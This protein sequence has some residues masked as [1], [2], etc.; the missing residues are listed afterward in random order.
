MPMEV[1]V[2]NPNAIALLQD[3]LQ[4][5]AR[6]IAGKHK[7]RQAWERVRDEVMIPSIDQNFE[8]EGRPRKWED[9]SIHTLNR[10]PDRSGILDVSGQMRRSATAKARFHIRDNEMTYGNWPQRRWFGPIHD[11]GTADIPKRQ[12][13]MIQQPEDAEHIGEII[14]E[15]LEDRVDDNI[16]LRYF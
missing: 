16:K 10:Q 3:D 9:V 1:T 12:F 6:D 4:S 13:V 8:M 14:M 7:L 2:L 11:F 15:W 5:M